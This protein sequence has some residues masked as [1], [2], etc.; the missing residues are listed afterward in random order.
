MTQSQFKIEP[1]TILSA[2]VTVYNRLE[3][4]DEAA[5]VKTS[6]DFSICWRYPVRPCWSPGD[7]WIFAQGGY[8]A[9][10]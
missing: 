4:E 6:V 2:D 8:R 3:G 5:T 1:T 7:A 10:Q 9:R